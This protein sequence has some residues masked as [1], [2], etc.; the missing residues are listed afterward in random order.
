MGAVVLDAR[1][2]QFR[3]PRPGGAGKPL[4]LAQH[5]G[6]RLRTT[7]ALVR[8]Q[9]LP[10]EQKAHEVLEADRFDLPAQAFH[11]VAM[12]A[13]Q[14]MAFAP[15]QVGCTRAEMPAQHIAF[16]FQAGQCLLDGWQRLAKRCGYLWRGAGAMATQ[17]GT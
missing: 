12:N 13:R 8:C 17:T 4:Q 10:V 16:S 3:L 15:L 1:K 6:Q 2:Q 11:G 5:F 14:Q 7:Q 9:V